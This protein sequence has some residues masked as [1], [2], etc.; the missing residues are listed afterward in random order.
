MSKLESTLKQLLSLPE[1]G[2]PR[3]ELAV[4]LISDIKAVCVSP[5]TPDDMRKAAAAN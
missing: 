3:E 1:D 2:T 4:E 5:N